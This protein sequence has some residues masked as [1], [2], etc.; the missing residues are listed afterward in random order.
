[1]PMGMARIEMSDRDPLQIHA[2]ILLHPGQQ[3]P[4]LALQVEALPEFGGNDQLEQPCVSRQLPGAERLRDLD[5]FSRGS[6]ANSA[7]L[8]LPCCTLARDV[9]TVSRPLPPDA[10]RRIGYTDGASLKV[11]LPRWP[12]PE[13]EIAA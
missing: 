9:P 2:Q 10:V 8:S 11:G 3:L 4:R 6:E 7:V 13:P 12:I 5:S 1:M